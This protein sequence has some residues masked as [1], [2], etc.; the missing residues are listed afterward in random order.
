[1]DKKLPFTKWITIALVIVIGAIGF[2]VASFIS[3]TNIY[4]ARGALGCVF[5]YLLSREVDFKFKDEPI[6]YLFNSP[7][8]RDYAWI[9]VLSLFFYWGL[10]E[11]IQLVLYIIRSFVLAGRGS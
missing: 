9:F 11:F 8:I 5:I 7:H 6:E 10:N 1:M 3:V 2:G 4:V